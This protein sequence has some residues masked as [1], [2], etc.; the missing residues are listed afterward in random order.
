[1]KGK[2]K[3][4]ANQPSTASAGSNGIVKK[5]N[6]KNKSMAQKLSS[7]PELKEAVIAA[8]GVANTPASPKNM[9]KNKNKKKSNNSQKS[10]DNA[11]KMDTNSQKPLAEVDASI[12]SNGVQQVSKDDST[13][14]PDPKKAEKT[15]K[16]AKKRTKS[17]LAKGSVSSTPES[18]EA[19]ERRTVF[20]GNVS[21]KTTRKSLTRFFNKYGKVEAVRLRC[22]AVAAPETTKKMAV[23]TKT[24][25]EKR[26]SLN[27]YVRFTEE[28]MV[29]E[30]LK[31]NGAELDQKH[32]HVD[33]SK[34]PAERN[35][36]LAVFVGNL[37]FEAE[38][39]DLRSH[40]ASCGEVES[41][42]IVRDKK[43]ASGKGFGYVNFMSEDAVE[44]ALQMHDQVF[45]HRQLRVQ[46]CN[47]Q[48]KTSKPKLKTK[49]KK[50]LSF[51]KPKA[52]STKNVK[53]HPVFSGKKMV[54]T[55]KF[56]KMKAKAKFT[57][58]DRKK[59]AIAH[60]LTGPATKGKTP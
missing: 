9:K 26:S 28:A 8:S 5:K 39:E 11:Q 7:N 24:F 40:F 4:A 1:M 44:M 29:E 12:K 47:K 20:V 33:R 17:G 25:H 10:S 37:A 2:K 13:V 59:K 53:K 32:L 14:A 55:K 15:G 22:A 19:K 50:G 38:E 30:A 46:R 48:G 23:I 31:A 45:M 57:K 43:L 34:A 41:V 18:N 54:E 60:K 42:R 35:N 51:M 52:V 6:K 3:A 58:E 56:K 16:K 49:G 21:T 27:A 36:K